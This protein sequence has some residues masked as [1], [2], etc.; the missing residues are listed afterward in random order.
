[1]ENSIDQAVP[2]KSDECFVD[3]IHTFTLDPI[4]AGIAQI[5]ANIQINAAIITVTSVVRLPVTPVNIC[6]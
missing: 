4:N 6:Q 3:G 5:M 2:M 1:M